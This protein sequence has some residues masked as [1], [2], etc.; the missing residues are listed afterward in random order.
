MIRAMGA[1]KYAELSGI[2][3]PMFPDISEK[4]GYIS[5]LAGMKVFCGDE[6]GNFN[7]KKQLTRAEAIMTIYNYL[8]K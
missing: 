6:K 4:V 7:P 3:K 8:T 5:I 2:F 1:E